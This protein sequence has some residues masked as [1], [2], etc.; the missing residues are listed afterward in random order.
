MSDVNIFSN[1]PKFCTKP[2]SLNEVLDLPKFDILAESNPDTCSHARC[3]DP[4]LGTLYAKNV[5]HKLIRC[6]GS[7]IDINFL[8]EMFPNMGNKVMVDTKRWYNHY[9]CDPDFNVYATATRT[10]DGPGEPV[11]FQL[12]K[13]N[14]GGSGSF[15]YPIP[16]YTLMDKDNQIQ[17]TI[18]DVNTD[19]PYGHVITVIPVDET[20]TAEIKA[21]RAYTILPAMMVGGCST[22]MIGN[23]MNS[24]GYTQEVHP[25]RLRN[26]WELCTDILKG[27]RDK[28]QFGVIYDMQGNPQDA[29]DTYEAQNMRLGLRMAQN[30][31]AFIGTPVTNATLISGIN[32]AN[33]NGGT[34]G[35]IK[36]DSDHTGFYG[37]LP[38]L[39]F[40]GGHVYNYRSDL[41]F[42]LEA[43]FEPIALYQDSRKR[44]KK[45]MVIHGLKFMMSLVDRTNKLVARQ[46]VGATM[47]EAY[48]RLGGL[49]GEDYM[50][51]VAKLGIKH[52]EYMGMEL[53]FKK[54]DFL[55]DYRFMGSDYYNALAIFMAQDGIE[56]NGRPINPVEFY[57]YGNGN[58]TGEYEEHYLDFRKIDK[59]DRIGGWAS[60]SLATAVHCPDQ[61]ILVNPIKAA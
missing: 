4:N 33:F 29:W 57:T 47:W 58:W 23:R 30:V 19:T 44:T 15:S 7:A 61:H 54:G 56:E 18:T 11:S 50:T 59:T 8:Q 22:P 46:N 34:G 12:I 52:Y 35:T 6:G 10:A 37:F 48:K 28:I 40:G 38:T 9:M 13:A 31:L 53:D 32:N 3:G 55:S 45:F 41:G 49:T 42:D 24:L 5:L 60:E 21:N 27:Y 25:L 51:A 36:I 20:V 2:L 14:H 1:D 17:Y 26:D 39:K 16:G 43:D